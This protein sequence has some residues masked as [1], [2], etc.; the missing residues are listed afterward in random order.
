MFKQIVF[1]I[2][3]SCPNCYCVHELTFKIE[4]NLELIRGSIKDFTSMHVIIKCPRCLYV[5]SD[6]MI[7]SL[8]Q[9]LLQIS[10]ELT[11][12]YNKFNI[13]GDGK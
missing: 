5:Y 2:N 10:R 1:T 3:T 12:Y 6:S 4:D 9:R 7:D 11:N 13:Q 8:Q